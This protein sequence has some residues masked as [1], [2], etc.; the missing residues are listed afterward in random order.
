M[1]LG[2]R[3][4]PAIEL[5]PLASGLGL[6]VGVALGVLGGGGSILCVPIFVYVLGLPAREAV[7]GSLAVVG[8]TAG[9]GA[10]RHHRH[11]RVR[12]RTAV[13]FGAVAMVGA[14]IGARL[15]TQMTG[16]AQLTLFALT[17]FVAS[18]FM[19]R[20]P[21]E[22]P[23]ARRP[24][25]V[26]A[27]AALGVGLLTGMVGVGGGFVIVPALVLLLAVPMKEAVGTSLLIMVMNAAA[28]F[29]G[30]L[31]DVALPWSLLAQF[32][33]FTVAGILVGVRLVAHIPQRSLRRTFAAFLV[34]MGAF[35]LWQNRHILGAAVEADAAHFLLP[36]AAGT[37]ERR[38]AEAPG[39]VTETQTERRTIMARKTDGGIQE[40]D[41]APDPTTGKEPSRERIHELAEQMRQMGWQGSPLVV[42][43]DQVLSGAERYEAARFLGREDEV[44]TI[45]LQELFEEAGMDMPQISSP[46]GNT[47]PESDFFEDYLRD[48]PEHIRDKYEV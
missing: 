35:I 39:T 8:L 26:V 43:A 10:L 11:G 7:A 16:A 40:K 27:A 29:M 47:D 19:A 14:Y 21:D 37:P 22:E 17:L 44:P 6:L 23:P 9:V 31:G 5:S 30:Y 4:G 24:A 2:P 3:G 46:E 13:F 12:W 18:V 45:S 34:L 15:G 41:K 32:A 28:G 36:S 33:A 25:T 20:E 38:R 1:G 42:H 48:L